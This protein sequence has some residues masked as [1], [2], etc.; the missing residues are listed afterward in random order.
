MDADLANKRPNW[1][2]VKPVARSDPGESRAISGRQTIAPM[3]ILAVDTG[4]IRFMTLR[5]SAARKGSRG[6]PEMV[7]WC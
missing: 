2:E 7:R 1:H 6:G 4:A 3:R 5:Q